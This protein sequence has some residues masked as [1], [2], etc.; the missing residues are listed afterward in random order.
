MRAL[1]W[2]LIQSGWCP[3]QKRLGHKRRDT[4]D[5]PQRKGDMRTQL[6]EGHLPAKE[7]EASVENNP[8]DTV[9]ENNQYT[10]CNRNRN[11]FYLSQAE[12]YSPEDSLSDSSEELLRRSM[13]FNPVLYLVRT[14][15]IKQVR[16]TFLQGLKKTSTRTVSQYVLG[17]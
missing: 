5:V 8:V 12:D 1:E 17:P 15:N 10:I 3:Y 11:K 13:V 16:G 7:R 9:D 14:K 2:T 6:E 4:R